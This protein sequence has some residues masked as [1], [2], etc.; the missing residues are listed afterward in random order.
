MN[1][2]FS[3]ADGCIHGQF[4]G[5][6]W[7]SWRERW[8]KTLSKTS[9]HA[10]GPVLPAEFDITK[11]SGW[12]PKIQRPNDFLDSPGGLDL[13]NAMDIANAHS[14]SPEEREDVHVLHFKMR[15]K[16][17]KALLE[18][19]EELILLKDDESAQDAIFSDLSEEVRDT[20]RTFE[21]ST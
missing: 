2:I 19:L 1:I 9:K 4:P 5:R 6:T 17:E 16:H 14:T 15:P 21:V 18:K 20:S 10:N 7:Q 8:C 12:N 11:V 13:T 3:S